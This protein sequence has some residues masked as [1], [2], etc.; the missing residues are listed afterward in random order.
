MI[1]QIHVGLGISLWM[2]HVVYV[3]QI[4]S[5][6][7]KPLHLHQRIHR[8]HGPKKVDRYINE[9]ESALIHGI[10][11]QWTNREPKTHLVYPLNVDQDMVPVLFYCIGILI[12]SWPLH[13]ELLQ[14]F[15]VMN[16]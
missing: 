14:R 15:V 8:E 13:L 6:E 12:G 9:G 11:Q 10:L 16:Q 7:I 3:Q 5:A 1:P 2:H 4:Q